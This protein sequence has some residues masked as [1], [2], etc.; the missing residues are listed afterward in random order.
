MVGAHLWPSVAFA[1]AS[2][3]SCASGDRRDACDGVCKGGRPTEAESALD[4][5]EEDEEEEEEDVGAVAGCC[6]RVDQKG[7]LTSPPN[8]SRQNSAC[9]T[10]TRSS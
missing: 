7:P 5:E 1:I 4:E 2:F 10:M 8:P 3:V 6:A 9:S